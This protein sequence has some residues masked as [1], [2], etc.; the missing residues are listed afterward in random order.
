MSKNNYC[1]V[2]TT[3]SNSEV[4]KKIIDALFELKLV[5][6]IQVVSNVSS[7]FLWNGAVDN[8]EEK[9]LFIK[10]TDKLYPEVQK[11]IKDNH[12]YEVPEIIKIPITEGYC[13]YLSWIDK[14]VK[15]WK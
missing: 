11:C 13:E 3:T 4:T 6:C 9:I 12:D 2:L 15:S 1:V 7:Y 5:A 14:S 8:S 10:T